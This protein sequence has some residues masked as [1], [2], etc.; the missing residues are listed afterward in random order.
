[1]ESNV[2]QMI[3][4]VVVSIV[5]NL[6]FWCN[7]IHDKKENEFKKIKTKALINIGYER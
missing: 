5:V 7:V 3:T 4:N 6:I 1:M 2:F